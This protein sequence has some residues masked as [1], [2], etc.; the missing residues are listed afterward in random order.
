MTTADKYGGDLE[1]AGNVS[2]AALQTEQQQFLASYEAIQPQIQEI[3]K[4]RD[5]LQTIFARY[6]KEAQMEARASFDL[7]TERMPEVLETEM[8]ARPLESMNG[9]DP[10]QDSFLNKMKTPFKQKQIAKDASALGQ[11]I[12]QEQLKAWQ[13][14]DLPP[15][16]QPVLQ[17]MGEEIEAEVTAIEQTFTELTFELTGWKPDTGEAEVG[18]SLG[19]RVG[20]VTA[21]VLSGNIDMALFGGAL[22][23]EGVAVGMSAEIAAL[24]VLVAIGAA[25]IAIPAAIIAGAVATLGFGAARSDK[26]IEK[27]KEKVAHAMIEGNP[28]KDVPGLR[29]QL[30]DARPKV[31]DA[32]RK[33]LDR[34]Q[35]TVTQEV[36]AAIA[37]RE[38]SL[39]SMLEANERG[40][41]EREALA[42]QTQ[43]VLSQIVACRQALR[44]SL[45][46][47]KL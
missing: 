34:L 8:M 29:E 16:L 24:V 13:K 36:D 23:W 14:T 38:E 3:H 15:R 31:D 18:P 46:T 6:L 19:Q 10:E 35:A 37:A 45:A 1:R 39:Q 40:I 7:L 32:V 22:G 26:T 11:K 25:P 27:V 21:G 2:L 12:V 33:E 41:D 4:R 42:A 28:E 17:R 9:T 47:A 5:H 43:A 44:N 20:W 30:I